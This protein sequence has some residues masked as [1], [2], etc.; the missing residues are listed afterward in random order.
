VGEQR[1]VDQLADPER[2]LLDAHHD[3]PAGVQ[4]FRGGRVADTE[5]PRQ[6]ARSWWT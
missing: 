5:P 4:L 3:G 6:A 1:Q 2:H